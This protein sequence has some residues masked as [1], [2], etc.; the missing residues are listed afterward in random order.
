MV[1]CAVIPSNQSTPETLTA[2]VPLTSNEVT[3]SQMPHNTQ[4][5]WEAVPGAVKYQLEIDCFH[6]CDYGKWCE[7]VDQS[8]LK[9]PIEIEDTSYTFKFIGQQDH[10]WRVWAIDADDNASPKSEWWEISF[11]K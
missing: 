1:S 3:F 5:M 4:F 11:Q 7:E 10:R 6:C 8:F 9:S 2:P